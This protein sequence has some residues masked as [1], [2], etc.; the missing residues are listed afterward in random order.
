MKIILSMLFGAL[1]AT[2]PKAI[3]W[4]DNGPVGCGNCSEPFFDILG[5]EYDVA[6]VGPNETIKEITAEALQG[7]SIFI[8]P[9]G[10]YHY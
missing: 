5:S 3:I 4:K 7:I 8:Q 10:F 1:I 2:K 6:Y 9:G